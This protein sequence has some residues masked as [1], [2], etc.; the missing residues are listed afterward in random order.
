MSA[1]WNVIDENLSWRIEGNGSD[2]TN[3]R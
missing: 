3:K 2:A 1:N